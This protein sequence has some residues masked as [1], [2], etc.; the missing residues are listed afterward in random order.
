[1][2]LVH[3]ERFRLNTRCYVAS[4]RCRVVVY[5]K[6]RKRESLRI[7]T[8][9][10]FHLQA[11]F[12]LSLAALSAHIFPSHEAKQPNDIKP[13]SADSGLLDDLNVLLVRINWSM[14]L[15]S[16]EKRLEQSRQ[17]RFRRGLSGAYME[18]GTGG[19]RRK[20]RRGCGEGEERD[21]SWRKQ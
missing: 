18:I 16:S 13:T 1:M 2:F 20:I 9:A 15:P 5:T 14:M 11:G 3:D 17:T 10:L 12:S 19:D 4:S 21:G 7:T 8:T 6:T